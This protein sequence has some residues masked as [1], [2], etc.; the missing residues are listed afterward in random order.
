[1]TTTTENNKNYQEG[2]TNYVFKE[3]GG[4]KTT[5]KQKNKGICTTTHSLGNGK[6]SQSTTM[7]GEHKRAGYPSWSFFFFFFFFFFFLVTLYNYLRTNTTVLQKKKKKK[8]KLQLGGRERERR[9]K[10]KD[11]TVVH[12]SISLV[13]ITNSSH[14]Q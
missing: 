5:K 2:I 3:N 10:E 1:M 8:K 6:P 13:L 4:K 9:E 14:A 11:L 7:E 12:V